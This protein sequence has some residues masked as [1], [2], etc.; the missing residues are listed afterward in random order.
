M[1]YSII[2][3]THNEGDELINTI[4][5]FASALECCDTHNSGT[6]IIVVDDQSSDDSIDR[7]QALD[8]QIP[9]LLVQPESRCG[10]SMARRIG[11]E[12]SSGKVII[13]LDAHISVERG[14][15]H[16]FEDAIGELGP[17]AMDRTMFAPRMHNRDDHAAFDGG[18]FTPAPDMAFSSHMHI[19]DTEKPYPVMTS[20]ACGHHITRPLYNYIGGYLPCFLP[21]WGMDEEIGIRLWMMGGECKVI[22]TM[23]MATQF[24]ESFSYPVSMLSVTHNY[25]LMARMHLDDKRFLKVLQ[26]RRE[27]GEPVDEAMVK[28]MRDDVMEWLKWMR[29]KRQREIDELFNIFGIEW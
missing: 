1:D 14:W 28:L 9:L 7:A 15:L 24:T 13:N 11:V 18:Q 23:N 8:I 21:P 10:T 4:T 29:Q 6:E 3:P 27:R 16:D 17:H 12:E 20:I 19:P 26:A 2:I 25:L 5:C 22:P